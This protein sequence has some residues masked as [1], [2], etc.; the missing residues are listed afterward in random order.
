MHK[1]TVVGGG[2]GNSRCILPV[3]MDAIGQAD[4]VI[5][6]TRYLPLIEHRDVRPMGRIMETVNLIRQLMTDFNV[7]VVVSG[8]PLIYSLYKTLA[9]NLSN[10]EIEI[11]PGIGSL[12]MLASKLGETVENAR[13]LS[14]HGRNLSEGRLALTVYENEK[15]FLLCDRERGPA[16]MAQVMIDFNLKDVWM[17]A[18]EN[19]SYENE[20]MTCGTPKDFVDKSF[21]SLCVVMIKNNTPE[22]VIGKPL[23]CDADFIRDKTPMT[24]EEVR[25]TI[26]GKMKLSPDAVVWDV[27]AGTGSVSI[28]CARQCPFGEV[29]AVERLPEAAALI[30]KNKE[31]FGTENLHIVHGMAGEA[32]KKLPIPTH[33]FIGGSGREMTDILKYIQTLGSNI[34]VMASCVTLETLAESVKLFSE[35]FSD[36]EIVQLNVSRG[37]LLGSYHL[38]DS[39]NPV[40][41][42]WAKTV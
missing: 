9:K 39:N 5:A 42:I 27:G 31:K 28:E 29:Y 7:A 2:P 37:R 20:K 18:V 11:I 26:I 25:W 35:G 14:A 34:T 15:V 3:G 13:I 32:V 22:K 12:Q 30:E 8:D 38:L 33:V 1:L 21:D 16:W 6:D 23:L 19:I 41:L 17:T 4:V 40:T 36:Y 10:A 24:K